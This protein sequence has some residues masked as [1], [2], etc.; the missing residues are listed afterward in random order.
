MAR[1]RARVRALAQLIACDVHP[2]ANL[3]VQQYLERELD[4]DQA[5]SPEP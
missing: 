1:D 3:R 5:L 4:I 2:L